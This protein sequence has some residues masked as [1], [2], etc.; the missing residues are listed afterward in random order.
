MDSEAGVMMS[1]SVLLYSGIPTK[2]RGMG[3]GGGEGGGGEGAL[4]EGV[5]IIAAFRRSQTSST[6]LRHCLTRDYV[7]I[8]PLP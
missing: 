3:G 1:D 5:P 7:V 4:G 2:G 8:S 6:L